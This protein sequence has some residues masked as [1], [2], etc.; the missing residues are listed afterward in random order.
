MSIYLPNN[1]FTRLLTS[2]FPEEVKSKVK[3]LPSAQ[4]T[5]NILNDSAS[6]GLIPVMD[7]LRH[8]ELFISPK[9]GISFEESLCNSYIYYNSKEK[10]VDKI[11]LAGDVSSQEVILS[12]ILFKEIYGT[13]IEIEILTDIN[14]IKE[15]NVLIVG[16]ENFK[17][18]RFKKGISFSEVMVETLSLPFVNYI[19]ASPDREALQ[20]L[21]KHLEG[22]QDKFYNRVEEGNFDFPQPGKIEGTI[23][24]QSN[25]SSLI[26]EFDKQ[27]AEGIEQLLRLPYFHSIVNDIVEINF[28]R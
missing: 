26:I 9:Y 27:D 11:A 5:Q 21:E 19:F 20:A 6:S 13:D 12:K 16:D 25:I 10:E 2:C 14:K 7:L 4:L 17:E 24:F 28:L 23:Y 3:Y 15:K 22:I 8:K 18:E 1:I